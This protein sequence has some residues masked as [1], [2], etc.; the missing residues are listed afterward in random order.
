MYRLWHSPDNGI[1]EKISRDLIHW[2]D[3]GRL[4]TL[5]QDKWSWARGR[6]T[7]G[8]VLDLRQVPDVGKALLFYHGTGP[9]DESVVFD[10]YA[11][12]GIAWSDDLVNWNY[13]GK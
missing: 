12:L 3:T 5:G 9:E 13:P 11:C 8:M 6:L 7:A 1:G 2:E 4:I 10:Q